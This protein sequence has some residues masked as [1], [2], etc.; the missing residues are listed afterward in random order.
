MEHNWFIH[1]VTGSVGCGPSWCLVVLGQYNLILF[2]IKC[3]WV[4]IGLYYLCIEEKMK[5]W[6]YHS[7]TNEQ[8]SKQANSAIGPWKAEMSNCFPFILLNIFNILLL[9]LLSALKHFLHINHLLL[10]LMLQFSY[11]YSF[12]GHDSV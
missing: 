11:K 6:C 8:T 10:F 5:M 9:L 2:G 1:D 4:S 7:R 3:K 12:A